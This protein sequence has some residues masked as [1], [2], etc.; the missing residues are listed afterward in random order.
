MNEKPLTDKQKRMVQNI[1]RTDDSGCWIWQ[2][3]V[4]NSGY[5]RAHEL[6]PDRSLKIVSAQMASY[7]AFIDEVPEG[8]L[9]KQK[10]GNRLCI[11]PEHLTLIQV[12]GQQ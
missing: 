7:R 9:V 10:C 1:L 3:Q 12:Q 4:S 5:G 6:Q 8:S 2:G 11:N